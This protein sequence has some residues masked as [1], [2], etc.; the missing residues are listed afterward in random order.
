MPKE[1]SSYRIPKYLK[2]FIAEYKKAHNYDTA[3]Q[4]LITALDLLKVTF[5][6]QKKANGNYDITFGA[7]TVNES[8]MTPKEK[9]LHKLDNDS[10]FR[11][12]EYTIVKKMTPEQVKDY[13]DHYQESGMSLQEYY[14]AYVVRTSDTNK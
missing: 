14:D 5:E 12:Q 6:E 13:V 1:T 10:Q 9:V 3:T 4:V 2:D 7:P 11:K 8:L